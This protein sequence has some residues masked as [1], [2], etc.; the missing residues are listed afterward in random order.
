LGGLVAGHDGPE[1]DE[2]PGFEETPPPSADGVPL[3]PQLAAH[4]VTTQ[5]PRLATSV[6]Q[7]ALAAQ[8]DAH[9]A[10]PAAQAQRHDRLPPQV[11]FMA[12]SAPAQELSSHV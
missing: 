11:E 9:V 4:W 7:A 1:K 2:A 5:D 3:S 8:F 6:S 10:S 12:E